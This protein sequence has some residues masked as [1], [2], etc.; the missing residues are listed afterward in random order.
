MSPFEVRRVTLPWRVALIIVFVVLAAY[1][2]RQA[3]TEPGVVAWGLWVMSAIASW[4]ALYWLVVPAFVVRA[5]EGGI[6][7][8]DTRRTVF[9]TFPI[10]QAAWSE[11]IGV[12]TRRQAD[13]VGSHLETRVWLRGQG[14]AERR[15]FAVSSTSSGYLSFLG[16]LHQHTGMAV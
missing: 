15:S 6:T 7:Y 16:V 8:V 9:L 10:V 14:G 5:D 2:V 1:C 4:G 11:V 3:T 12:D 13:R